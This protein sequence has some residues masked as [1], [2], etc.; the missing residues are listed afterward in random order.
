MVSLMPAML[1]LAIFRLF[2]S[3][4]ASGEMRTCGHG[5]LVSYVDHRLHVLLCLNQFIQGHSWRMSG[6]STCVAFS[7][8]SG[9]TCD[10]MVPTSA[11]P[12]SS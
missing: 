12:G 5:V 3:A 10:D 4:S 1:S 6:D 9:L 11:Q 2:N 8:D 7:V